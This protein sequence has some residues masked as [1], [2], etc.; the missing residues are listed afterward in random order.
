MS[1]SMN[2]AVKG[3]AP[4]QNPRKQRGPAR[5][6]V[7]TGPGNRLIPHPPELRSYG[8]VTSKTFRF[9]AL[10]AENFPVTYANLI[11]MMVFMGTTIL[12]YRLFQ[13][14]RLKRVKAWALPAIGTAASVSVVFNGTTAGSQ[15]DRKAYTD[16]SMGIEPAFVNAVP[17]PKTLCAD[18]QIQSAAVAF[19]LQV[20][21]GAVID[22]SV[23]YKADPLATGASASAAAVATTAGVIAYRGLDGL[24]V[25]ASQFAV[26]T[27]FNQV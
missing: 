12:P 22:V 1:R 17:D 2:S 21:V 4:R 10:S 7:A 19:N 16:T 25:A 8:L 9:V 13:S 14:V 26:P 3:R 27:G 24:A 6:S 11:D 15:G 18:F 5:R 23:D 20:P